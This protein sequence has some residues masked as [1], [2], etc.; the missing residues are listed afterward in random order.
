VLLFDEADALLGKRSEVSDAHDRYANIEV[1][2]LLQRLERY[3]G[4][5]VMT[6]NMPKNIDD[7]FQRRVHVSIQFPIPR[8]D[9]RRRIWELSIPKTAPVH[10]LD[11]QVLAEGFELSGGSIRNA[12]LS[13][14]FIAADTDGVI[15]M[16][17][18][19]EAV[20]REL[21]KLGRLLDDDHPLLPGPSKRPRRR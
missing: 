12:A 5:V 4:L 8:P 9:A 17:T 10:D 21:R 16:K 3:H 20:R 18:V 13:A 15:S 6:T 7:A 11:L 19:L 2:Y 1:A 14:A